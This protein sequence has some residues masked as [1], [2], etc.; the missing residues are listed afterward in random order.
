MSSGFIT[1]LYA[2][3]RLLDL[4]KFIRWGKPL[5][6][7][8][9]ELRYHQTTISI[10]DFSEGESSMTRIHAASFL[11]LLAIA[12][13]IAQWT[14]FRGP[15]GSGVGSATGYPSEF[16]PSKNVAWKKTVPYGQS[17]PVVAGGR[18]YL[19]AAEDG[20]L[21]T[22]A[23]DETSG[24][25]LWRRE[26]KRART[27]KLFRAND[28][29]SPTPVA[30]DKGVVVFFPDYG[31]VAYNVDG[32]ERWTHP[33]GPFKNF[34][35]IAASPILAGNAIVQVCDQ[36]NGSFIL[37]LDRA[38]GRQRW[39]TERPSVP[40]GWATPMVYRP[41]EGPVQLV[42]LGSTRLDAYYLDT[43]EP[44]WWTPIGSSGGLGT[45]VAAGDT[46]F[47]TTL[48]STEPWMDSFE[49]A[50][51]KYDTNK[52]HLISQQEFQA[53]K[54]LGEHFG[55]IDADSDGMVTAEEWNSARMMGIGEFGSVA[56]QPGGAKG[57]LEP[58]AFRWRF[59]KNLPMIPAPLVYDGVYY[60]VRDG[61]IITA[62][63][64]ASGRLTKEG[65]AREALGEYYA[66]PIAADGKVYVS[67]CEGKIT[68]LKAG[69]DWE[70]LHTNDLGEEVH[71][72]PALSG[73]SLYVRTRT[74]LYSFKQ[75]H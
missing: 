22:L 12:P 26:T 34:Y 57:K 75:P 73:G 15:N 67:S 43:G 58:S 18:V 14:Q 62:L 29:A 35:G 48:A 54:E 4:A 27:H 25:E 6:D 49:T 45:P 30:D 42:T 59:K 39:R 5:I 7:N 33:L 51:G 72:T 55:W 60:T 13:A 28:P 74:T 3:T 65:R 68:V 47:I 63:D 64:P 46:I 61:G 41:A 36:S 16:S 20:H 23:F 1:R 70:V 24:R 9:F 71:A 11:C 32:K 50:L 53:D 31:L 56:I 2:S 40:V 37:A 17:S 52:D 44:I 21:L 69:S 10:S 38:T 19:T 8:L 66:S